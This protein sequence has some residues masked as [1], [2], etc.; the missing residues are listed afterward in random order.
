MLQL[1]P[2][3]HKK[4]KNVIN[5]K[6]IAKNNYIAKKPTK[7]VIFKYEDLEKIKNQNNEDL[8]ELKEN[9]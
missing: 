7:V 9:Y 5:N 3:I 4:T 6:Y 8:E 1:G 2:L